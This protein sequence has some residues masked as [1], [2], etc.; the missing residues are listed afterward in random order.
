[1]YFTGST[2]LLVRAVVVCESVESFRFFEFCTLN[3][4]PVVSKRIVSVNVNLSRRWVDK[5][6]GKF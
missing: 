3:L 5:I 6:V 1:M 4:V 2:R